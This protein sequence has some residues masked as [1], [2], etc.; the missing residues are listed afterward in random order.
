MGEFVIGGNQV[1][2]ATTAAH[3][4]QQRQHYKLR[5]WVLKAWGA[6]CAAS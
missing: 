3:A 2:G 4:A 1:W 6:H 5:V